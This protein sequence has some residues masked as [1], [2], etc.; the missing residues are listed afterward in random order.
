MSTPTPRGIHGRWFTRD[1]DDPIDHLPDTSPATIGAASRFQIMDGTV[2][3]LNFIDGGTPGLV[4]V[5]DSIDGG[6]PDTL[7]T[8][9]IYD[10]GTL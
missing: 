8:T 2:W 5:S 4:F 3:V 6:A 1:G 7:Y 9:E 10:G